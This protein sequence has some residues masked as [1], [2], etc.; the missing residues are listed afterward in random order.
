M[1]AITNVEEY[2]KALLRV[3]QLM[4]KG[5]QGISNE[6]MSEITALRAMATNY[7]KVRYDYSRSSTLSELNSLEY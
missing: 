1:G 4:N 3:N 5:S 7:E 6:E 2:R